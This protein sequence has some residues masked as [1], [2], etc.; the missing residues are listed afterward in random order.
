MSQ[1]TFILVYQAGIANLFR[2]PN[3]NVLAGYDRLALSAAQRALAVLDTQR[4]YQGDYRT[5]EAMARGMVLCGADVRIASC[6]RAGDIAGAPWI[7]GL[8]DCP[9]RDAANPPRHDRRRA[10]PER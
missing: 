5:A 4:V 10:G 6:N 1:L 2:V 7:K 3:S 8:G 9:F